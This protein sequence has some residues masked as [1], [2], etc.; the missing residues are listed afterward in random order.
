MLG[1]RKRCAT[2]SVPTFL[3][4]TA[5]YVQEQFVELNRLELIRLNRPQS[6]VDHPEVRLRNRYAKVQPWAYNRVHLRGLPYSYIN[7]SPVTIGSKKF[8][9]CQGPTE[10][11]LIWRM[12]WHEN[13]SVIVM[14]TLPTEKGE[15][16]CFQYYPEII[17]DKIDA[18]DFQV[19][20]IE[21]SYENRT[22]VRKLLIKSATGEKTVWHFLFQGW[23]DYGIPTGPD[24]A[25]LLSL[26]TLSESKNTPG[27]PRV[28]H[29][30]AGCGRTGTFIAIDY[31]LPEIE[32]G[33]F[34]ADTDTD[35]VFETV[36]KL[37]EQRMM[38]VYNKEQLQFIYHILHERWLKRQSGG[39]SLGPGTGVLDFDD[40]DRIRK[41]P[42]P[43]ED[44]PAH[45]AAG[46]GRREDVETAVQQV[47]GGT[48]VEVLPRKPLAYKNDGILFE[49]EK[50]LVKD[51]SSSI[52]KVKC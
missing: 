26:L 17:G 11:D 8:I 42:K 9:A 35:C 4:V 21:R 50:V 30:S 18:G 7:A 6:L 1:K 13:V 34:D 45:L 33:A 14:L 29:C 40:G 47:I 37:R 10:S 3:A 25:A 24:Q 44:H 20:L 52:I 16:K 46:K 43:N 12:I 49:D 48:D 27:S 19:M 2:P 38:M 39:T 31:L 28:V 32:C 51:A 41:M 5:D 22:D 36:N 23:P 15:D